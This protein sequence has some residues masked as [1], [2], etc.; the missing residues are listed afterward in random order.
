VTFHNIL[1][2]LWWMVVGLEKIT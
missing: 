1:L 2:L